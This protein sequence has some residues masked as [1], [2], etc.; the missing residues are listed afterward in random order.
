MLDWFQGLTRADIVD[1]RTAAAATLL[2]FALAQM[3]AGVYMWTFRGLS[4]SRAF[5]QSLAMGS[6]VT[7]MLMLA[8]GN[9]IAAGVGIA[10]GLSVIRFRLTMRDPRDM[11]FVFAALGVGIAS[12]LRA[13]SAAITGALVF[14]GAA[15]VLHLSAYGARKQLDGLVRFLAATSPACEETVAR[16]LRE[17]CRTFT[18]VTLRE[19]AEGSYLEHSYQVSIPEPSSRGRLVS[20]LQAVTGVQDVTLLMQEPTLDL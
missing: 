11:V 7:C 19:V 5:V 14:A 4:Y 3:L 8:I 12:G 17:N 6:I 15:V 2:A 9:S 10:G 16:I 18:L 1:W 20:A 13:Y